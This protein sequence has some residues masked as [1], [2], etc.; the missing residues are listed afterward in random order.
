MSAAPDTLS[1][2]LTRAAL[3]PALAVITAS[4]LFDYYSA[5]ALAQQAQ[6]RQLLRTAQAVA[7]RLSPDEAGES[8]AAIQRHLDPEDLAMLEADADDQIRIL[9]LDSMGEPLV[10]DFE[11][12]PLSVALAPPPLEQPV[13]SEQ[14]LGA[15][16][17][18]LLDFRHSARGST[19][20]V[21]ISETLH[22][23]ATTTRRILLNTIWPNLLLLG[24]VVFLLRRGIRQTLHPLQQL[25]AAVDHREVNDLAPLPLARI[26]GEITPLIG[27][28]NG[29]LGRVAD[30]TT[31]QQVFLSG[32]AHQL[33][34]PLA[35][36]QT[37]IELAA[38]EAPPRV[39]ERLARVHDAMDRMAHCT[40]QM[41][42]L[43]RAS[44]QASSALDQGHVAL[45]ELLE[46]AA[47]NWLDLALQRQVELEFEIGQASCTGSHWMLQELLGNLIDNAIQHSPPGAQVAIRCGLDATARPWLEVEDEGP[48]IPAAQRERVFEPF[49]RCEPAGRNGSGLGLAIVSEVAKRHQAEV[50]FLKTKTGSGTRIRV[51]L[52]APS[53][54]SA[55]EYSAA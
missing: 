34:T 12:L 14:A 4:S 13:Y 6:D 8:R 24:V 9:A 16:A 50:S 17:V 23:R 5:A 40:Q 22:K 48:G 3:L 45:P 43:A 18:R 28:I 30:A 36:M 32:A 39:R 37:Q 35:G 10:G 2:R 20:R 42:A 44:A 7:S 41:L 38:Q 49:F 33:R 11:L 53:R 25:S 26:P 54:K 52:P 29:L 27:A 46:D 31:E 51:T 55:P 47:S 15:S 19:Q 1:R 21:L